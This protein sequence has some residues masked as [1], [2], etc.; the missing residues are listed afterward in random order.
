[1]TQILV[2]GSEGFIGKKLINFFSS[3][4]MQVCGVDLFEVPSSD[5]SYY[6]VSRL[7]PEWEEIFSLHRFD[8]CIN[9]AGSGSVPYSIAHPVADFEA[10]TLDTIRILDVIRRHD[11]NCRYVHISSAAV[12]GNPQ[13]LPVKESD[14]KLPLSPYGWHKLMS[15]EICREYFTVYDLRIAIIR[16]FSVYGNGLKKQL[17]WDVCNKL[18]KS[19]S[20][21]LFGTGAESRD[22]I[23]VNDLCRLIGQLIDKASFELNIVNAAS[24]IETSIQDVASIFEQWYQ[25]K[26]QIQFS[27]ET[28]SGD[29]KNW[30]ADV[31]A[32]RHLGFETSTSF[33]QGVE[34][35]IRWF[36]SG[37]H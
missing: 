9:A 4:K 31:N 36:E 19:D 12:Y 8:F 7:S 33:K 14:Q 6:K 10:N 35:Y 22:F 29:P 21:T 37:G 13:S 24:G 25:N 34:N 11:P 16:P 27:G 1:M 28:R 5:Y 17:L 32:A 23:E 2:L 26:K 20:I 30:R 3:A 15:E 18:K